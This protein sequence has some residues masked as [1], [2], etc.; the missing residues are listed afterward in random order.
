[1]TTPNDWQRVQDAFDQLADL[2]PDEQRQQLDAR[3]PDEP[4]LRDEV[5]SLL[6]NDTAEDFLDSPAFDHA[7]GIFTDDEADDDDLVGAHLGPWRIVEPIGRGGM[8]AVYLA[9]RADGEFD[10]QVAIK[11]VKRGMDTDEI[12]RRFRDERRL[13]ARLQHP[14]IARLYDGG[15]TDD[16][17][18][19]LVMEHIVGKPIDAY[20]RDRR[21]SIAQRLDL[22][23]NVCDAVQYAHRNLIVHRDLKPANILVTDDG[24]AKLLDF[25]IARLIEE[26]ADVE[27]TVTRP[28]RRMLT[29]QY[30]SPEQLLG[31]P[32][33]TASDT[34]SLGVILY[35]MIT[36]RHPF[37]G[38]MNTPES[39]ARAVIEQ[40]P[41]RP[42]TAFRTR[43][44][45]DARDALHA[46]VPRTWKRD[47]DNI[48]LM[49]LRK[50]PE[51]RYASVQ[52]LSEDIRRYT[53]GLPVMARADTLAYRTSRFMQRNA[54]GVAV[55]V[56][57]LICLVAGIVGTSWQAVRAT[58]AQ[59]VAVAEARKAEEV[60][61]FL[62]DMLRAADPELAMG[63]EIT[64]RMVLDEAA[65]RVDT[66]FADQ[67]DIRAE[68]HLTIGR[69]Y[70]S[71][72]LLADSRVHCDQAIQLVS[73]L[74]GAES[75]EYADA[76]VWRARADRELGDFDP[77]IRDFKIA[78]EICESI[79]DTEGVF[80]ALHA[81]GR[82]YRDIG[83]HEEAIKYLKSAIELTDEPT[84]AGRPISNVVFTLVN[85]YINK[86]DFEA[87]AEIYR[88]TLQRMENLDEEADQTIRQLVDELSTREPGTPIEEGGVQLL[89]L[90]Y[91]SFLALF[92]PYD[93]ESLGAL[94]NYA[95]FVVEYAGDLELGEELSVLA[96][97]RHQHVFGPNHPNTLTVRNN[98][99]QLWEYVGKYE[100]AEAELRDV[101]EIRLQ[102]LGPDHFSVAETCNNLASVVHQRGRIDEAEIL[103]R[104]ALEILLKN[105]EPDHMHVLATRNNLAHIYS[106]RGT[107][108]LAAEM[109]AEVVDSLVAAYGPDHP[110]TFRARNNLASACQNA[111]R[112]E[113]AAAI[114]ETLRP[115][116]S[117]ILPPTHPTL[118]A[119]MNNE[120]G[121]LHEIGRHEESDAVFEALMSSATEAYPPEHPYLQIFRARYGKLLND[122]ERFAE[123]EAMLQLALPGIIERSGEDA[124][125]TQTVFAELVDAY[126]GLG[127]TDAADQYRARLIP[128][129]DETPTDG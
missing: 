21:L 63:N 53:V 125:D 49:A 108:D 43:I 60:R 7:Q 124:P 18:P 66:D 106:S 6:A 10:Q 25:G 47:L 102:V 71:L 91:E 89:K 101:L 16:G 46:D 105:V 2:T 59:T 123:A 62:E 120:A 96:V 90:L 109:Y 114:Y 33:T 85:V 100:E 107:Y 119:V 44:D 17:R 42:S 86:G 70:H 3:F 73:E 104:Q 83:D 68:L 88:D 13:L 45:R 122:M 82:C 74:H 117:E 118:L 80:L 37:E 115:Q 24:D 9:Q 69:T 67:P 65:E 52:Q 54:A 55:A 72:G 79:D 87:A 128:A 32:I 34:Y 22:F 35:L 30:A 103:Y 36:G 121:L 39:A 29:P 5:R 15:V 95:L 127:D 126:E 84:Q 27:S 58:R 4:H 50:E 76:L 112:L 97:E 14:A 81:L 78:L 56:I 38:E 99:G 98:L 113:D 94:N 116:L 57:I 31:E 28:G 48:V 111:G 51:R 1:M 92:G 11:V 61:I 12:V 19:Y 40:E 110:N 8:G 41:E 64:V 20:C 23:R 77:A 93:V 26:D 75:M 129:A